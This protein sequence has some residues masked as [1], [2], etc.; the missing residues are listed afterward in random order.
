MVDKTK[1]KQNFVNIFC[2]ITKLCKDTGQEAE[3]IF[4]QGKNDAF[5]DVLQ[6]YNKISNNGEKSVSINQIIFY[7]Q[8]KIDKVN[9]KLN[10]NCEQ[11]I[12]EMGRL[13]NF[14]DYE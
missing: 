3:N 4:E 2:Q 9:N 8:D 14:S 12:P 7:I 13:F 5:E 6:W 10:I 11:N 1:F